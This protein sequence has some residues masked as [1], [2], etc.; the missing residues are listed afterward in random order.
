MSRQRASMQSNA[1]PR[2]PLHVGHVRIVIQVR[3]VL[4]VLLNDAKDA[5]WRFA[6]CLTAR[7]GRS[8]DPAVG[9]VYCDPL[10][11]Q[12]DDSHDWL[13]GCAYCDRFFRSFLS[14]A[15]S[16]CKV[17]RRNQQGKCRDSRG[18][19]LTNRF[20]PQPGKPDHSRSIYWPHGSND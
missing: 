14:T 4:G 6:S 16:F 20:A 3:V 2:E 19:N 11:A 9:I 12:R 8:H 1:G 17:A 13:A 15:A 7:N 18:R 10:A 5:S